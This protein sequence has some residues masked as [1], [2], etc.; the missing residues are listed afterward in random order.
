MK[1]KEIQIEKDDGEKVSITNYQNNTYQAY[2]IYKKIYQY[3]KHYRI[4]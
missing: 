3:Y 4:L 2:G 1:I